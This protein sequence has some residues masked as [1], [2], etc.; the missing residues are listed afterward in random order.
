MG[1]FVVRAF[2]LLRRPL[3]FFAEHELQ[4]DEDFDSS[5]EGLLALAATLGEVKPRSTPGN[6]IEALPSGTFKEWKKPDSDARCPICLDDY[7]DADAVLKCEPCGHWC[8][9]ECLQQ[10]LHTAR[11]CPVCRGKVNPAG[12]PSSPAIAG[13]S[14]S[15][16]SNNNNNNSDDDSSDD[17]DEPS[18]GSPRI[19]TA[20]YHIL[21]TAYFRR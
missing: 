2:N 12:C 1:D 9:K 11:T 6:V 17:E 8:H 18:W 19:P 10:W 4:R 16:N 14:N 3:G 5:Y 20:M 7:S 21:Q 13:P 15:N